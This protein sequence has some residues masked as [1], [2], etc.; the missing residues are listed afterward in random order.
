[1]SLSG[2]FPETALREAAALRCIARVDPHGGAKVA[3]PG[4]APL[5]DTLSDRLHANTLLTVRTVLHCA[6]LAAAIAHTARAQSPGATSSPVSPAVALHRLRKVAAQLAGAVAACQAAGFAHGALS[7][8]IVRFELPAPNVAVAAEQG[9]GLRLCG[10]G[11]ADACHRIPG[12][13]SAGGDAAAEADMELLRTSARDSSDPT[14]A[15]LLSDGAPYRPPESAEPVHPSAAADSWALG[16]II[17]QCALENADGLRSDGV[18]AAEL[19]DTAACVVAQLRAVDGA[20]GDMLSGLLCHDASARMTP[21]A[22]LRHPFLAPLGFTAAAGD[23]RRA[24]PPPPPVERSTGHAAPASPPDGSLVD[25]HPAT[26]DAAFEAGLGRTARR[27]DAH[28]PARPARSATPAKSASVPPG[29][30]LSLALGGSASAIAV[31]DGLL[32]RWEVAGLSPRSAAR[33]AAS[34]VPPPITLPPPASPPPPPVAKP[35][36]APVTVTA[37]AEPPVVAKPPDKAPPPASGAKRGRPPGSD[38][39]RAAARRKSAPLPQVAAPRRQP[40]ASADDGARARRER[41]KS[42]TPWWVVPK[43]EE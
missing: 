30:P 14:V 41:R 18:S 25:A 34:R 43:A 22:A 31:V 15:R 33:A 29:S 36:P 10:F 39:E 20:L 2:R 1:M 28:S 9:V 4:A 23:S 24:M 17:A 26:R 38:A 8:S 19:V 40:V 11:A 12:A 5:H 3:H 6:A 21:A 35:T 7:P 27:A 13:A 16:A 37:V 32:T 42:D